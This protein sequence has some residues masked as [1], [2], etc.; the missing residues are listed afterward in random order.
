MQPAP[1]IRV[2]QTDQNGYFVNYQDVPLLI[3]PI[4][5]PGVPPMYAI[6]MYAVLVPAPEM[7][8]GHRLKYVSEFGPYQIERRLQGTWIQEPIVVEQPEE[9]TQPEET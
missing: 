1:T 4:E 6:P 8:P 2:F 7:I 9:D 5:V 3:P